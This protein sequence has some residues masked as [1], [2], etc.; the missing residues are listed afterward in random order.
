MTRRGARQSVSTSA[1]RSSSAS[2]LD[3]AGSIVPRPRPTPHGGDGDPRRRSPRW[4]ELGA[5][6]D[7]ALGVGIA[8]LVSDGC[9]AR[10]AEPGG[11]RAVDVRRGLHDRLGPTSRWTTTPPA[12]RSPSGSPARRGFDDVVLVTLGTGIG[13][14]FVAGGELQ[15]GATASPASS[16][17]WS[18]TPTGRRARAAG[19]VLGALRVRRRAGEL[20][21]AA[22][23]AGAL[24]E[25]VARRQSTRCVART[26][27]PRPRRRRAGAGGGRHVRPLGGTRPGQPDQPPRPGDVRARRRPRRDARALPSPIARWFARLL[28]SPEVRPHPA[29][30]FASW[31]S[32]PGRSGRRCSPPR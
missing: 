22:A 18:S 12:P 25:V 24:D 16:A 13:G 8:G 15:R 4:R 17:T 6:G 27:A 30:A 10:R 2:S 23:E 3:D 9:A 28:Y 29:L 31:A 32:T 11:Q 5:G 7:D 20:A 21:R 19:G 26:C 14:G 1:A